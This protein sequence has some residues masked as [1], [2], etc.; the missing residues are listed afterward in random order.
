MKVIQN[1]LEPVIE[2]WDDPGDYPNGLA[3]GPLPSKDFVSGIEGSIT[4][5]LSKK[6]LEEAIEFWLVEHEKMD[7]I[8][9]ALPDI[10]V[11]KWEIDGIKG[12][13]VTLYVEEFEER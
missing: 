8:D 11:R 3:G 1:T 13:L 6:E 10:R 12:D 4:V 9:H 7:V 2:R 5:Q